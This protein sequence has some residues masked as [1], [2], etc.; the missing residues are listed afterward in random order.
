M[1]YRIRYLP[2]SRQNLDDILKY[3]SGF[4]PG[5]LLRFVMD[6]RQCIDNL[7]TQPLMYSVYADFPVYRHI[8]VGDYIVFYVVNESNRTVEIHRILNGKQNVQSILD[9]DI[10]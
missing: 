1:D 6:Q 9:K 7:R 4:Y 10:V 3:F 2:V 5:T 8:P